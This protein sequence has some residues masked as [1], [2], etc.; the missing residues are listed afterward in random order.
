MT[1]NCFFFLKWDYDAECAE[2]IGGC[3]EECNMYQKAIKDGYDYLLAESTL[4]EY[5]G[6]YFEIMP[7]IKGIGRGYYYGYYV[8]RDERAWIDDNISDLHSGNYAICNDKLI[9]T[10][11][12]CR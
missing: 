9:I 3:V 8:N 5:G 12:A 4:V 7:R 11:Y 1:K 10:D 6:R 2:D